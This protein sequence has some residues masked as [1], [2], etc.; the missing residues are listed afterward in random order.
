[1]IYTDN[2]ILVDKNNKLYLDEIIKMKGLDPKRVL[3]I[4]HAMTHDRFR[5]CYERNFVKEYTQIQR[6]GFAKDYDYWMVFISDKG[7]KAKYFTTYTVKDIKPVLKENI[8]DDFPIL[9]EIDY[10]EDRQYILE[11][12]GFLNDLKNRLVIEWGGS[13]RKWDQNGSNKKEIVSISSNEFP[14]YE[15]VVLSFNRL[16]DIVDNP[17]AHDDY[18]SAL[19][20]IYAVY[21]ISNTKTGKLYVGSAYGDSGLFGRWEEYVR[22]HHGGNKLLK[23][24]LKNNPKGYENFKF[25]ILQI[26]A[27]NTKDDIVI[28]AES[29]FKDKLLSREFGYNDN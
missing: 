18:V 14:G 24:Y 21:L 27:K 6:N 20:N 13:V 10:T 25:S 28:N 9:E 29:L 15:N 17:F 3:L 7:T 12:A 5:L 4:R 26:F 2:G 1:M 19:K 22:T 8:P 11:E 16:K 23:E